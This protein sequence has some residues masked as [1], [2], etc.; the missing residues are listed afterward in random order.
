VNV[1]D[2]QRDLLQAGLSKDQIRTDIE[3]KNTASIFKDGRRNDIY[4]R[5]PC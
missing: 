2:V 3:L 1:Q 5:K 4:W